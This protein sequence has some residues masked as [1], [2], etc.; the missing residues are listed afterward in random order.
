MTPGSRF[1]WEKA[2]AAFCAGWDHELLA[3][4]VVVPGLAQ[5]PVTRVALTM[6]SADYDRWINQVIAGEVSAELYTVTDEQKRTLC[7]ETNYELPVAIA[8]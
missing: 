2:V 7:T 5:K 1:I 4:P 6:K 8:I 3:P